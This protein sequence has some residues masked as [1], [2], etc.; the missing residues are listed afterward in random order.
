MR[1]PDE[2]VLFDTHTHLNVD[3]FDADRPAVLERARQQGVGEMLLVGYDLDSSAAA[4]D[5]AREH[6]LC[7]AAG[8]QPHYAATTGPQELARLRRLAKAPQVVALGEIG[9]DYYRDRAPRPDQRRLLRAQLALA[10][11]LA[12]PVV[13][14]AREALDDLLADLSEAGAGLRGAMHCFSGNLEQ[15]RSFISLGFYV[16]IAGT[17]TYPKAARTWRVAQ[18]VPLDHLLLETDCPWLPPQSHRGQRNE[19]AYLREIAARVAELRGL[20]LATL[21]QAT[22]QNAHDL[23]LA[24]RATP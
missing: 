9:L 13:I 17:V 6:G 11:E 8:I 2:M 15:A 16:S 12:L 3:A 7:A 21:A 22:T 10:R 20:P 18:E 14:H 4:V 24:G 1:H 23:F 5:L 19:P